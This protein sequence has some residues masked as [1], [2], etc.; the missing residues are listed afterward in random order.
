LEIL[1]SEA[2]TR[3]TEKGRPTLPLPAVKAKDPVVNPE[4]EKP[5]TVDELQGHSDALAKRSAE[6]DS[7]IK[8]YQTELETARG[9]SR[10][11]P[12]DLIYQNQLQAVINTAKNYKEQVDGYKSDFNVA[13]TENQNI[14]AKTIPGRQIRASLSQQT[15]SFKNLGDTLAKQEATLKDLDQKAKASVAGQVGPQEFTLMTGLGRPALSPAA[16]R[17]V[18]PNL[19]TVLLT[20]LDDVQKLEDVAAQEQKNVETIASELVVEDGRMAAMNRLEALSSVQQNYHQQIKLASKSASAY[21]GALQDLNNELTVLAGTRKTLQEDMTGMKLLTPAQKEGLEITATESEQAIRAQQNKLSLLQQKF[22][23][24]KENYLKAQR[25]ADKDTEDA[26]EVKRFEIVPAAPPLATLAEQNRMEELEKEFVHVD[27]PVAAPATP[28]VLPVPAPVAVKAAAPPTATL[29]PIPAAAAAVQPVAALRRVTLAEQE[30]MKK[31][32]NEFEHVERPTFRPGIVPNLSVTPLQV[33]SDE[34]RTKIFAQ[35]STLKEP[36]ITDIKN[37]RAVTVAEQANVEKTINALSQEISAMSSA[38]NL[39]PAQKAYYDQMRQTLVNAEPYQKVL[40]VLNKQL[41]GL[42]S[43][44]Q[45]LSGGMNDAQRALFENDAQDLESEIQR[46][47]NTISQLQSN[48]ANAYNALGELKTKAE[49]AAEPVSGGTTLPAPAAAQP[50]ESALEKLTS[51]ERAQMEAIG[52]KP[53]TKTAAAEPTVAP[54]PS[55]VAGT[56]AIRVAGREKEKEGELPAAAA[57]PA[58]LPGEPLPLS[59][60]VIAA[61]PADL[62]PPPPPSGEFPSAPPSG[63]FKPVTVAKRA[64]RELKGTESAE[65]MVEALQTLQSNENVKPLI[66]ITIREQNTVAGRAR[67][68]NQA[69]ENEQKVSSSVEKELGGLLKDQQTAVRDYFEQLRDMQQ[70]LIDLNDNHTKRDTLYSDVSNN[71]VA[72]DAAT[73]AVEGILKL[74]KDIERQEENIRN[75]AKQGGVFSNAYLHFVQANKAVDKVIKEKIGKGPV[76]AALEGRDISPATAIGTLSPASAPAKTGSALAA[77]KEDLPPVLRKRSPAG[78]ADEPPLAKP[79]QQPAKEQS[80]ADPQALVAAMSPAI[81]D[82]KKQ[83]DSVGAPDAETT[84]L[85]NILNLRGPDL[86]AAQSDADQ[87]EAAA[88]NA[89]PGSPEVERANTT[90]DKVIDEQNEIV[91]QVSRL[92]ELRNWF[93]GNWKIIVPILVALVAI[94]VVGVVLFETLAPADKKNSYPFMAQ[95][96]QRLVGAGVNLST[97]TYSGIEA[98]YDAVADAGYDVRIVSAQDLLRITGL[99]SIIPPRQQRNTIIQ[100]HTP[101]KEKKR[102]HSANA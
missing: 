10:V 17:A 77:L 97:I 46:Q 81:A 39:L 13:L 19:S 54:R 60:G 14:G 37:I 99:V 68:I 83:L 26:K 90:R 72:G 42:D 44:R 15:T 73:T 29:L 4:F 32:E 41:E 50:A 63:K 18:L 79:A 62:T 102:T 74:D 88:V 84:Q 2:R 100:V 96:I 28:P 101:L 59:P 58:W 9:Q 16:D 86:A 31:I 76:M 91:N 11:S 35:L 47:Q 64:V 21:L 85:E 8:S 6:L 57:T 7:K 87:A 75:S 98:A 43:T 27:P 24:G 48:F 5:V 65:K 52:K 45:T 20:T 36:S 56:E 12:E 94:P 92:T 53:S 1:K 93:G 78:A 51:E 55:A 67:D 40:R 23:E 33:V 89:A 22:A 49:R 61:K 25:A 82:L 66:D 34:Q 69:I 3:G 38:K 80:L 71:K 30:Q 70:L 95:F